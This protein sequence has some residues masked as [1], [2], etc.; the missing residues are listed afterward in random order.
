MGV[1]VRV[2]VLVG[3]HVP[4][5][6]P[7]KPTFVGV[8]VG[9]AGR[10]P[11]IVGVGVRVNVRVGVRVRLA[12]LVGVGPLFEGIPAQKPSARVKVP[13]L[14]VV[15]EAAW[16]IVPPSRRVEPVLKVPPPP[17]I[18]FHVR[19][20]APPL[21]ARTGTTRPNSP[22]SRIAVA[23]IAFMTTVLLLNMRLIFKTYFYLPHDSL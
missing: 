20:K 7:Q 14:A 2:R 15:P 21:C 4:A 10:V 12:V 6:A 9:V 18:A 19:S 8:R 22:V 11:V 5:V 16:P 13:P 1:G 23:L 17:A 3:V